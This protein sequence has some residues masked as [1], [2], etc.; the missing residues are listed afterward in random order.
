MRTL[1]SSEP[2]TRRRLAIAIGA[3]LWIVAVFAAVVLFGEAFIGPEA[4]SAEFIAR[5]ADFR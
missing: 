1:D 5:I 3:V 4:D 2:T